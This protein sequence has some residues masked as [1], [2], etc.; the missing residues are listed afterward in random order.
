MNVLWAVQFTVIFFKDK[1]R[2]I[3]DFCHS[4]KT[5]KFGK[6]LKTNSTRLIIF[7]DPWPRDINFLLDGF[8]S[9]NIV[10][11]HGKFWIYRRPRKFKHPIKIYSQLS[12]F[13]FAWVPESLH[14]APSERVSNNLRLHVTRSEPLRS[15][16]T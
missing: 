4:Y 11:F 15:S 1:D 10:N 6:F 3:A 12:Y 9:I 16:Y 5:W 7:S 2:Y 13:T 8:L 14:G